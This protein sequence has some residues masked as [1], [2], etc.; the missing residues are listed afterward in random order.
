MPHCLTLLRFGVGC[1]LVLLAIALADFSPSASA[2]TEPAH[3]FQPLPRDESL[4]PLP[5]AAGELIQFSGNRSFTEDQLRAPLAEQINDIQK[6]GLTRPR[7]DDTAYYLAVFYR[8]RGFANVDVKWDIRGTHLLLTISEGQRTYL[9]HVTFQGNRAVDQKTLFEYLIGGTEERLLQKPTDFPFVEGDVQSGVARIRGLYE[10]EGHLDA[11]VDDA[12][13]TYSRDRTRA[14]VLVK[15]QEGPRYTFG[16]VTFAGQPIYSKEELITALGEPLTNPYTTQQVNTMQHNLQFYFKERGYYTAEV[17]ASGDPQHFVPAPSNNRKVPVA[18]TIKPGA[19]Y[20]FDGATVTGLTRLHPS[21][22]TNRFKKLSG[23]VY[24]PEKLDERFRELLRTGLFSNLRVNTEPLKSSN[25][26]Q[27]QLTAEEAKAKEIGFSIGY[28]SY[29]G[30]I[31]GL[32]LGD[33]DIFGSGRPLTL[34]IDYSQ[35]GIKADLIYTNPWFLETDVNFRARLFAHDRDEIG[36]SKRDE[37]L[38]IEFTG[39][40]TK[41][42]E[43]GAFIETKNVEITTAAI[44][45]EDLGPTSY[46]IATI[47]LTQSFDYRDSPVSP[48]KGWI[49]T[50]AADFDTIGGS[51]SFARGTIRLTEF[52]PIREHL[53]LALGARAGAIYPF[54]EVP[55]DERYFSGGG[56]TVRSF[57]ER[58]LGPH[59]RHGYPIGGDIFTVFNAELDFPLRGALIGAVFA[60]A[61]NVVPEFKNAGLQNMRY[62]LGIGLRY[63]LPIGPIRLDV[64]FNPDPKQDESWGAVNFSFGFAF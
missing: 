3:Q 35:R 13:I 44:V 51:A 64:G 59:D 55:I 49:A 48:S 57:T 46:Q 39:K 18:F 16:Q 22:V 40:P 12:T 10:S 52:I 9:R 41:N 1:A 47:G 62:A 11:K 23:K 36:Y 4:Q 8:K 21:V 28:S 2:A 30:A 42:I 15:I 34:D 45:P 25:E 63:K 24:S 58:D 7:A 54:T 37:G 53:L 38:R 61:G 31:F 5:A 17:E 14:D 19:I 33:R 20:K 60:D 26:V 27:I 50:T 56:N 29:E 32:R 6:Q 43:L